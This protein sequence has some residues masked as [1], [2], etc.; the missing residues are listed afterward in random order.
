MI[1]STL[2]DV[3]ESYTRAATAAPFDFEDEEV[4]EDEENYEEEDE[5]E[6]E[7]ETE[8][9]AQRAPPPLT[10]SSGW[11]LISSVKM[12]DTY[13]VA[14]YRCAST[15]MELV[16]AHV[17]GPQVH[18]YWIVAHKLEDDYGLPHILQHMIWQGGSKNFS[19]PGLFQHIANQC[20]ATNP[21]SWAE[22]DHSCYHITTAGTEGIS[23]L[24][25]VVFD[26]LYAPQLQEPSFLHEVFYVDGDGKEKG[27]CLKDI[28]YL[29]KDPVEISVL[30]LIRKS[31]GDKSNY[32][33]SIYGTSENLRTL[34]TSMLDKLVDFHE[35]YYHLT[36]TCLVVC[37]DV[38]KEELFNMLSPILTGEL[39]KKREGWKKPWLD[40][41]LRT[42][43]DPVMSRVEY[44]ATLQVESRRQAAIVR[45][46][47][48]GPPSTEKLNR[49]VAMRL[50]LEYL[51]TGPVVESF[52]RRKTRT[53]TI[54]LNSPDGLTTLATTLSITEYDLKQTLFSVDCQNVP[55]D[56]IS[57]VPHILRRTLEMQIHDDYEFDYERMCKIVEHVYQ[58]EMTHLETL[59]QEK[60]AHAIIP[61][62]LY[63]EKDSDL[64]FDRRVNHAYTIH[65]FLKQSPEFWKHVIQGILDLEWTTVGVVP[66]C[67]YEE[68]LKEEEAERIALRMEQEHI[69]NTK[70]LA[71]RYKAAHKFFQKPP[72]MEL[73]EHYPLPS[74]NSIGFTKISRKD[75]PRW[76]QGTL[77]NLYIDDIESSYVFLTI[78][79]DTSELTVEER[80]Y[81]VLFADGIL[82]SPFLDNSDQFHTAE[83]MKLRMQYECIQYETFFGLE[84]HGKLEDRTRFSCGTYPHLFCLRF[85]LDVTKI[86]EGFYWAQNLLWNTKWQADKLRQT[87]VK[88]VK[89][90]DNELKSLGPVMTRSMLVDS[91]YLMNSVPKCISL[92]RQGTFLRRIAESLPKSTRKISKM[93]EG[94]RMTIL[95]PENMTVHVAGS[96]KKMEFNLASDPNETNTTEGISQL[97]KKTFDYTGWHWGYDTRRLSNGPD[98]NWMRSPEC[99]AKCSREQ[100][101]RM[102]LPEEQQNVEEAEAQ[103]GCL[104]QAA[105]GIRSYQDPDY[106]YLLV[107]LQYFIQRD[108]GPFQKEI[109][110]AKLAEE[111]DIRV[112]PSEGL[113]YFEMRHCP[114]VALAYSKA[115]DIIA[116]H[117]KV[118]E[119]GTKA[120][121][122]PEGSGIQVS[123]WDEMLL[124]SAKSSMI[125]GLSMEENTP[126]Y[127]AM[128]SLLSHY[129]GSSQL[130]PAR[131]RLMS[132]IAEATM[133][134]VQQVTG[135]YLRPLFLEPC[136]C[137]AS[138]P[139]EKAIPIIKELM[140][141]ANCINYY[142]K[143]NLI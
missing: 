24:L 29:E 93:L 2:E 103:I 9:S 98:T 65:H 42:I 45:V 14:K 120:S 20:Y 102:T 61:D 39:G 64:M 85:L 50:V 56:M 48:L 11:N 116:K 33:Y 95:R 109:V 90:I 113:L 92:V 96:L 81:L 6:G 26:H 38:E 44:P 77:C 138:A 114:N 108:Y 49:C 1:M 72:P 137:A 101:L 110:D 123:T 17:P 63:L 28:I 40:E 82:N 27:P 91:L 99:I 143:F 125:F 79:M 30:E 83:E 140:E 134:Q 105:P 4:E 122:Q 88:L 124:S 127:V 121:L 67:S 41:P 129:K 32:K 130:G 34:E 68:R 89:E 87:C 112:S 13:P 132:K 128:L 74:V 126:K 71:Q 75:N 21:R 106:P 117:C 80:K 52:I 141:Y 97:F 43:D 47:I 36:N 18:C 19:H 10:N 136:T 55:L 78:L 73:L 70:K 25:P 84:W 31:F 66:S 7:E 69:K 119:G 59:V 133:S 51:V 37:G 107:A 76:A 135:K 23:K 60:I 142:L 16:H 53:S 62:F 104:I 111:V 3:T 5:E 58:Q 86:R 100:I 139:K 57:S 35:K 115:Y 12:N 15:G 8:S 22:R 94:I 118:G 131:R 46:G 54:N